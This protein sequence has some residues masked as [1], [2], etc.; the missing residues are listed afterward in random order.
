MKK[1][2]SFLA[3]TCLLALTGCTHPDKPQAL[4][5]LSEPDLQDFKFETAGK[6]E[7]NGMQVESFSAA[8]GELE[9]VLTRIENLSPELAHEMIQKAQV[10]VDSLYEDEK[11]PYPGFLSKTVKCA[12]EFR[13]KF[14]HGQDT[15]NGEWLRVQAMANSRKNLGACNAEEAKSIAI[16]FYRYCKKTHVFFQFETVMPKS[17]TSRAASFLTKVSC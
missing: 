9:I 5:G 15:D 2:T 6:R 14:D 16:N 11:S 1:G 7:V 13:P 10:R 17:E 8:K 12:E 3:V 4:A